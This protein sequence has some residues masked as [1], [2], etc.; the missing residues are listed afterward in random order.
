MITG[1]LLPKHTRGFGRG[2]HAVKVSLGGGGGGSLG[3]SGGL[4]VLRCMDG[5]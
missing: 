5:V 2:A 3:V 4:W 1:D